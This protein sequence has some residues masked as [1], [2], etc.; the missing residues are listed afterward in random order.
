MGNAT[1]PSRL[2][3]NPTSQ[4]SENRSVGPMSNECDYCLRWILGH[5][6]DGTT[7]TIDEVLCGS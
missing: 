3:T 6:K 7:K 5:E 2:E 1:S 4:L